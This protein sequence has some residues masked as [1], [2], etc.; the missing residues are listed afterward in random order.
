MAEETMIRKILY[1]FIALVILNLGC[2]VNVNKS[3]HLQDGKKVSSG[4]VTVNG[5]IHVGSRCMVHGT[6]RSV[7]G[8]IKINENSVVGALQ[9]VN[10]NI[11]V[12]ESVNIKGNAESVNGCIRIDEGTHIYG[13]VKTI[14]GDISCHDTDIRRDIE[15]YNGDILL[16][17]SSH[18]KGDVVIKRSKGNQQHHR[19]LKITLMDHSVIEGDIIVRD[20][21]LDV[22]LYLDHNSAVNG[23]HPD[24][25][26]IKI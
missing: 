24:V 3:I 15:T 17:Q 23:R 16:A 9:S 25:E 7:N 6:C 14:N 1:I 21:N 8:F 11:E 13:D 22:K 26:V 18:V 12:G 19:T 2:K 5:N 20:E 10:G 4:M